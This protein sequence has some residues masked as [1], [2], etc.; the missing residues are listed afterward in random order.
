MIRPRVLK[1]V[2]L[3]TFR[4][5][6]R[7]PGSVFWTYGFPLLM[8]LALGFAFQ[9]K[10]AP[11]LP[12][13]VVESDFA[14]AQL[15]ALRGN[16]RLQPAM[17]DA[18]TADDEFRRGRFLLVVSIENGSVQVKLDETRPDSELARLQVERAL[19]APQQRPPIRTLDRDS[20]IYA[21]HSG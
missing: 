3:M 12:I 17:F 14:G 1:E 11:P 5:F 9:T 7:T 6:I 21:D 13:A 8:A 16:P 19:R 10:T 4:E 2:T 18:A 15:D 20:L